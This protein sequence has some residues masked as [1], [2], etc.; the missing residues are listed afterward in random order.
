VKVALIAV[1]PYAIWIL[2]S[3]SL[4]RKPVPVH[5]SRLLA[6]IPLVDW[7]A[8]LPL[9]LSGSPT[10]PFYAACLLI[11]PTAFVSALLLQRVAP[12]T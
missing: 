8:L 12:A 4:W 1:L 6:G 5:V 10:D 2:L 11:P 7:I 3:L 9:A